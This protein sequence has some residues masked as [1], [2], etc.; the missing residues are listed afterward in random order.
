MPKKRATVEPEDF[1]SLVAEVERKEKQA[2]QRAILYTLIPVG[3]ALILLIVTSLQVSTAQREV[4]QASLAVQVARDSLDVID[5]DL[6]L[7][8]QDLRATERKADSLAAFLG[9][10]AEAFDSVAPAAAA[11]TLQ[12][13][14]RDAIAASRDPRVYIHIIQEGQ[15]PLAN[16]IA[17]L[18]REDGIRVPESVEVVRGP[19][20]SQLRYFHNDDRV[21][22][23]EIAARLLEALNLQFEVVDLTESY[24]PG[25]VPERQYEVWLAP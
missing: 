12:I 16:Q 7:K 10:L 17:D 1:H 19:R 23:E 24:D 3:V 18:L 13:A 22:A 14:E 21:E 4:A 11:A 6:E 9:L 5:R 8:R 2:R 20:D 25:V 15:I